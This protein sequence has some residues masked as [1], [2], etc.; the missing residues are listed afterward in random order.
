MILVDSY[1]I[2]IVN[3]QKCAV[4]VS[5]H[6]GTPLTKSGMSAVLN[7]D[8]FS[9]K[10][11]NAQTHH[12]CDFHVQQ[13][14]P[15]EQVVGRSPR[16][17]IWI[18]PFRK[19][20]RGTCCVTVEHACHVLVAR[21]L[22]LADGSGGGMISICTIRTCINRGFG[23]GKA[24]ATVNRFVQLLDKL[25]FRDIFLQLK[26]CGLQNAM[27]SSEERTSAESRGLPHQCPRAESWLLRGV[28]ARAESFVL[29]PHS[30]FTPVLSF[31]S[32]KSFRGS[33]RRKKE[34]TVGPQS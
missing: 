33:S 22:F 11:S 16:C 34:S 23:N 14:R 18:P 17:P 27:T 12:G 20:L 8:S 31:P 10:V 2:D 32:A 9:G 5:Q 15:F 1:D 7:I 21:N 25:F 28:F 26:D 13:E 30:T 24:S 3:S 19:E 4:H 29:P 6:K